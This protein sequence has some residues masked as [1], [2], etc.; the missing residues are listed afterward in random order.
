MEKVLLT[1]KTRHGKNR[2][3]QHGKLWFVEEIRGHKMLLRS[4]HKTSRG[5]HDLRW[6]FLQNDP[7]II[8]EEQR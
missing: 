6:V 3:E 4:E 8:I 5:I 2:V 7:N 1:G